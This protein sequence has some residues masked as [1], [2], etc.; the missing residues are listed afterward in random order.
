MPPTTMTQAPMDFHNFDTDI[1][2]YAGMMGADELGSLASF[3]V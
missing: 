3:L 1:S 2:N